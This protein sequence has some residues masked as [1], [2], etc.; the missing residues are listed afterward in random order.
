MLVKELETSS[1]PTQIASRTQKG[2]PTKLAFDDDGKPT[3]AAT[4]F[5][6]KCGVAV[7]DL[8]RET[9]DKGEWLISDV[10]EKGTHRQ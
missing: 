10:V 3:P 4:A 5:A 1:R 9:T 7:E 2:P 8:G 6:K